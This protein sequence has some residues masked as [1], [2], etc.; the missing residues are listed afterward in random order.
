MNSP[1]EMDDFIE[2]TK[3]FVDNRIKLRKQRYAFFYAALLKR[4]EKHK[5]ITHANDTTFFWIAIERNSAV[6]QSVLRITNPK[7]YYF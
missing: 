1:Y 3:L 6:D 2:L 4:K 7:F 5:V